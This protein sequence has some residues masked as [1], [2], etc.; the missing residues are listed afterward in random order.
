LATAFGA[1]FD[2]P[3][4]IV[5]CV[6]GDGEAETGPTATAWRSTKFL[7]PVGDGAVLPILHL[8]RYK[9]SSQT[10]FAV[11]DDGE[12]QALFVGYG[13]DPMFVDVPAGGRDSAA[14]AHWSM[15][16][17][18]DSAYRVIRWIQETARLGRPTYTPRWPLVI[19]RSPKGWTVIEEL[20]GK[21]IEGHIAP[22]RCAGRRRPGQSGTP[23]GARAV[24]PVIPPEKL[25]DA[26]GRA[27]PSLLAT[28]PRSDRRME[29]SRHAYGG[30]LRKVLT[31]PDI[32]R[33]AVDVRQPRGGAALGYRGARQIPGR[34]GAAER[35]GRQLSHRLRG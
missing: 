30:G 16:T 31:R 5:A 15:A 24:A 14:A 10:P 22:T 17:A 35:S 12:L 13:Y 33:F 3:D 34:G 18:L 8:N 26:D 6:V 25:F 19:L 27:A 28:C 29:M 32:R 21:R 11:M 23:P 9:I 7:S 20:G 2:N 4:L 1:A